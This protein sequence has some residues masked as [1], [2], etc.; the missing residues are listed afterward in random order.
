MEL[1]SIYVESVNISQ[2]NVFSINF[3]TEDNIQNVYFNQYTDYY[4][5]NLDCLLDLSP[6]DKAVN[7][8]TSSNTTSTVTKS[9]RDKYI[10]ELSDISRELLTKGAD[11]QN[12]IKEVYLRMI[13]KNDERYT[14]TLDL[15]NTVLDIMSFKY[16]FYDTEEK[17]QR[18]CKIYNPYK[19][20]LAGLE[21]K[22]LNPKNSIYPMLYTSKLSDDKKKI[23][24]TLDYDRKNFDFDSYYNTKNVFFM[25]NP[26]AKQFFNSVPYFQVAYLINQYRGQYP[27]DPQAFIKL[28]FNKIVTNARHVITSE[29]NWDKMSQSQKALVAI[30]V[31]EQE[32]FCAP[33]SVFVAPSSFRGSASNSILRFAKFIKTVTL[34]PSQIRNIKVAIPNFPLTQLEHY[35]FDFATPNMHSLQKYI[36]R[37]NKTKFVKA[38]PIFGTSDFHTYSSYLWPTNDYFAVQ[39]TQSKYRTLFETNSS[40]LNAKQETDITSAEQSLLEASLSKNVNEIKELIKKIGDDKKKPKNILQRNFFLYDNSNFIK[41]TLLTEINK[42]VQLYGEIE[43]GVF[44]KDDLVRLVKP[45]SA[46][47]FNIIKSAYKENLQFQLEDIREKKKIKIRDN[48]IHNITILTMPARKRKPYSLIDSIHIIGFEN[49]NAYEKLNPITITIENNDLIGYLHNKKYSYRFTLN[50]VLFS[51]AFTEETDVIHLTCS[52]LNDAHYSLI[53]K[54]L[55]KSLGQINVSEISNFDNAKK[56]N[57]WVNCVLTDSTVLPYASKHF[58]YSFIT[59]N[60]QNLLNFDIIFLNKKGELLKW[61]PNEDKVPSVSFTIDILR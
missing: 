37:Y 43:V 10:K 2:E 1:A 20:L 38:S 25:Y 57:S 36:Y 23:I 5:T 41:H 22:E 49:F 27:R 17:K 26:I 42:K 45:S 11:Y 31:G 48:K 35:T 16:L 3:L 24:K 59:D 19:H 61:V 34:N 40:I 32:T 21:F 8:N 9:D 51:A 29:D 15:N 4:I 14:L 52:G 33:V 12:D 28:F 54:K 60:L 7:G 39:T 46:L 6:E 55:L 47:K 50:S 13:L 44:N 18:F 58:A 30:I 53:N 56:Q